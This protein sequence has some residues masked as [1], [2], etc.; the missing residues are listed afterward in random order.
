MD[1][2]SPF[3]IILSSYLPNLAALRQGRGFVGTTVKSSLSWDASP[4]SPRQLRKRPP[5]ISISSRLCFDAF[6]ACGSRPKTRTR[7]M[8][9]YSRERGRHAALAPCSRNASQCQN[10]ERSLGISASKCGWKK[11]SL[12]RLTTW[13]HLLNFMAFFS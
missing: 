12:M 10:S 9:N 3:R 13:H 2:R 6:T 5:S 7:A 4:S 1:G 8:Q 11:L